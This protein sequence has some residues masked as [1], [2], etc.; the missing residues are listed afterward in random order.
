MGQATTAANVEIDGWLGGDDGSSKWRS[1]VAL[2][3]ATVADNNVR[4][5]PGQSFCVLLRCKNEE[6]PVSD[7]CNVFDQ[8]SVFG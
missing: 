4:R 1:I 3:V 7:H 5:R 6:I 8:R 2:G